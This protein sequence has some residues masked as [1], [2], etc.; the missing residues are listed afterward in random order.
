MVGLLGDDLRRR[1]GKSSVGFAPITEA[2]RRF[3]TVLSIS[4][5]ESAGK[6][7]RAGGGGLWEGSEA[8]VRAGEERV[9]VGRAGRRY[10]PLTK[11][12]VWGYTHVFSKLFHIIS[13]YS[14]LCY[15]H[16]LHI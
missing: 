1:R 3:S 14:T 11:P 8:T 13:F 7:S 2:N 5:G 16:I 12:G 6:G 15:Y 9:A 4:L 10:E